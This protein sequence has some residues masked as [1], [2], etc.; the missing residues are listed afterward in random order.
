[1][2]EGRLCESGHRLTGLGPREGFTIPQ[3]IGYF[4]QTQLDKF[5]GILLELRARHQESP[6]SE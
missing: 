6:Y 1:M 4:P 2:Q 5:T 3:P